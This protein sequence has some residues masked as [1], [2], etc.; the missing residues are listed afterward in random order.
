MKRLL[1]MAVLLQALPLLAAPLALLLLDTAG[2]PV[3]DA[4]AYALPQGRSIPPHQQGR[5]IIDQ[6]QKEFVPYVSV[7][8]TGTLISFPNMDDTRHHVYSFSAAKP[9]ELKLYKGTPSQP[10][11]F[12][13]PGLVVLGCNIHDW[14]LGYLMVVDTPW[15]GKSD[16]RGQVRM[17]DLPAGD[18]SLQVWHPRM[19]S[20]FAQIV[21]LSDAAVNRT[22]TL[23][24]NKPDPR[25][26]IRR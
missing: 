12:D 10:V 24:L 11:L 17:V 16:E 21:K 25:A 13:K 6:V 20:E 3:P 14:M 15:F 1:M 7:V 19:A 5:A 9:F 18:Y 23:N 8:Q 22:L 26:E 4:V 2:K